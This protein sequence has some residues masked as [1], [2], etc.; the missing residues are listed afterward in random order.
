MPSATSTVG[1]NFSGL[2]SRETIIVT[3]ARISR[4]S[5]AR[6]TQQIDRAARGLVQQLAD[7]SHQLGRQ[8]GV[9]RQAGHAQAFAEGGGERGD[10]GVRP[11]TAAPARRCGGA[12]RRRGGDAA[13]A[14]ADAAECGDRRRRRRRRATARRAAQ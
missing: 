9:G 8:S 12:A 1:E 6:A 11:A 4:L 5:A 2:F 7:E 14:T 10:V 3:S 13:A